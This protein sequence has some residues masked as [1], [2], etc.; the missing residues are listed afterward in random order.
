LPIGL[1]YAPFENR[2]CVTRVLCLELRS[3]GC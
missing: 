2:N 3:Y 1:A